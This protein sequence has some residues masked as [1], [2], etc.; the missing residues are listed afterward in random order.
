MVQ[1]WQQAPQLTLPPGVSFSDPRNLY[2]RGQGF[3]IMGKAAPYQDP[4]PM[5][6]QHLL[7]Q[8]QSASKL[9]CPKKGAGH[10]GAFCRGRRASREDPPRRTAQQS[11]SCPCGSNQCFDHC[12]ATLCGDQ[13]HYAAAVSSGTSFTKWVP[14]PSSPCTRSSALAAACSKW[15][16]PAFCAAICNEQCVPSSQEDLCPVP[17]GSLQ[18]CCPCSTPCPKHATVCRHGIPWL[19]VWKPCGSDKPAQSEQSRS[20]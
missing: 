18:G 10:R 12:T 3:P 15:A 8:Q 6:Q 7:A 13:A 11:S 19:W 17:A 9:S 2:N 14:P 16:F 20:Q 5:Y 1:P 4:P